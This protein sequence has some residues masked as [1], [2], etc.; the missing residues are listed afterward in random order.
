[1]WN[2]FRQG[3]TWD[4][5]QLSAATKTKTVAE[6]QIEEKS[7]VQKKTRGKAGETKQKREQFGTTGENHECHGTTAKNHEWSLQ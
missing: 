5:I 1:M 6:G 2:C 4:A 3:K 7:E